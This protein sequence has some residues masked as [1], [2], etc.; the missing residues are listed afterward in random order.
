MLC[1]IYDNFFSLEKP[2]INVSSSRV[3]FVLNKNNNC[4]KDVTS[5]LAVGVK[6]L[7]LQ[8]D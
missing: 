7:E 4:A 5:V 6:T 8:S 2:L 1:Q 3:K